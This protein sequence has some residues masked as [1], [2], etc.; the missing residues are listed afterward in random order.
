MELNLPSSQHLS[1][2]EEKVY[3]KRG[4]YNKGLLLILTV[5]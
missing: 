5:L 3:I 4:A 2:F 1:T